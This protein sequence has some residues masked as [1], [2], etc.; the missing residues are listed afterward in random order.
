MKALLFINTKRNVILIVS[1]G[2]DKT[3]LAMAIE[4]QY[5]DNNMKAS[6][7]K[8]GELKERLHAAIL[9]ERQGKYMNGLPKYSCLSIDEI[10]YCH[11]G[12]GGDAHVL[13]S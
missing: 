6:L 11:F 2:T 7:I 1:T 4:N 10:N 13:Q 3:N 5:C 9:A 8:R 12:Q